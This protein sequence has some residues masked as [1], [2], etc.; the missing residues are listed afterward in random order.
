MD[1]NTPADPWDIP[2][3]PPEAAAGVVAVA[4]DDHDVETPPED[5]I[6]SPDEHP[7]PEAEASPDDPVEFV[8]VT[9]DDVVETIAVESAETIAVSD[10]SGAPATEH[11]FD[12]G[13]DGD[14]PWSETE[15]SFESGTAFDLIPPSAD[16]ADEPSYEVAEP[17]LSETFVSSAGNGRPDHSLPQLRDPA[18]MF[19]VPDDE[20]IPTDEP[21]AVSSDDA[22]PEPESRGFRLPGLSFSRRQAPAPEAPTEVEELVEPA[23]EVEVVDDPSVE[24]GDPFVD[25]APDDDVDLPPAP[26]A[27][28]DAPPVGSTDP[29]SPFTHEDDAPA[30]PVA[31]AVEDPEPAVGPTVEAT[32]VTADDADE[33][34]A[35]EADMTQT[36]SETAFELTDPDLSATSDD[37]PELYVTET[38]PKEDRPPALLTVDSVPGA[39]IAQAVDVV[40]A[41]ASASDEHD[42]SA[43]LDRTMEQLRAKA[44]EFGGDAVI[45]VRTEVQEMGGGFL[46]TASGTVV[47]LA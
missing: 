35:E 47:T 36:E 41:V 11:K 8:G 23:D 16:D 46:V 20:D 28:A 40:N 15:G 21:T 9:E 43:A 7:E 37:A 45:S 24:M 31:D 25:E 6:E 39:T 3:A 27:W 42:L 44:V 30:E 33:A 22:T 17:E 5:V 1:S 38:V 18:P 2:A 14:E 13:L 10:E 4:D 12:L 34:A 29:S 26:S 32:P 19:A